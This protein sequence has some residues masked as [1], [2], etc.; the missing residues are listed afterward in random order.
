MY[1]PGTLRML[2]LLGD[3]DIGTCL[4]VHPGFNGRHRGRYSTGANCKLV[5]CRGGSKENSRR[6]NV[7]R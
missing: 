3:Q 6:E 7:V 1:R 4:P 5:D 2:Q